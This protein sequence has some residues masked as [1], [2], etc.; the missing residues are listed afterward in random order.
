MSTATQT[1]HAPVEPAGGDRPRVPDAVAGRVVSAREYGGAQAIYDD[2]AWLR[3]NR[4]VA[5]AQAEG[6]DPFWLITKHADIQ[7]V[8]R[9]PQIFQNRQYRVSLRSQHAE[10][11]LLA[12]VAQAGEESFLNSVVG[13]DAPDHTPFRQMTFGDFAPKGIRGLEADIRALAREAIDEMAATGGRCDFARDVAMRFPM[14]VILSIFGAPRSDEDL[15]L[16]LARDFLNPQ[17]TDMTTG[18]AADDSTADTLGHDSLAPYYAYFDE[19][20]ESRRRNP[21]GDVA[22]TIANAEVNGKRISN[23]DATSY[24]ITILTAG[25]D[26]TASSASGGVWQLAA[27][28][29]QFDKVKADRSLIPGLVDEAIRWTTPIN[30]FMRTAAEDYVLRDQTV[31]AG[32]WLMLSY[33]SG[34]RDEEVFAESDRFDVTR[35]PNPQ[36]SFGYGAHV[37][38]GQHLARMEMR[39]LFEELF[40][41]VDSLSLNGAPK[42]TSSVL[43]G[44]V[45]SVPIS[46]TMTN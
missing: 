6:Y 33:L 8:G 12:A 32:D 23:W 45:K 35:K 43:V 18:V 40:D 44:G 38:L 39:L 26:T 9:Q 36:I 2:F 5:V 22:S 42:R 14:R 10:R 37:C 19:L 17:D 28:P 41:R 31:R 4:P 3:A 34:N 29:E 46:F 16:K 7:E 20:T 27:H 1:D 21:T 25:H 24:Y 30:H 11:E 13:M 15:F